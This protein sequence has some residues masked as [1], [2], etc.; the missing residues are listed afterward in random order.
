MPI[1][2]CNIGK[3]KTVYYYD[4]CGSVKPFLGDVEEI[5]NVAM[6]KLEVSNRWIK[7]SKTKTWIDIFEETA[8][9]RPEAEAL[10]FVKQRNA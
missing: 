6:K 4:G 10:F 5:N 2:F 9:W 1:F 7:L 3:E 8:K